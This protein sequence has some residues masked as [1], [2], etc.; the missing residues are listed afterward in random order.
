[1]LS[2]HSC[3]SRDFLSQ[4]E[5][6]LQQKILQALPNKRRKAIPFDSDLELSIVNPRKR[7]FGGP[8]LLD[9]L[10][11]RHW[12]S[13]NI[14]V[15]FLASTGARTQLSYRALDILTTRL[16][17]T[18]RASL[19]E[20]SI[21]AKSDVAI[22]ILIPQ[23]PE[24][25]VAWIA[26]LKVGAAFCPLGC[27]TPPE[28]L[29]FILKDVE[30]RVVITLRGYKEMIVGTDIDVQIIT[31]DELKDDELGSREEQPVTESTTPIR[32]I[33]RSQLAY[34]MYTSGSTGMPKGVGIPHQSVVQAL[35]AHDE[36]VPSFNR[37]LQFASPTFDVSIFETFFP[38]FRG[39]IVA[40]CD[41]ETMLGDLPGAMRRLSVDAAEL[42]PTVAASLLRTRDV[43][44]D[45]KFLMTIGE[46]LTRPIIEEF[47]QSKDKTGIL[48]AMY[49]PTEASIHCT[50][51]SNL[52]TTSKA[53]IIGRPLSTVTAYIIK[54]PRA[55]TKDKL[56]VLPVGHIGE[57]AV[58]GQLATS[59]INRVRESDA[60]F[61]D[62]A[63]HGR[64]YCTGDRARLLPSGELECLG[65]MN[66][67]QVKLRGQRVELGEIEQVICK[68]RG[69]N[70]AVATVIDDL[71][72]VFCVA[73][74]DLVSDADIM[75]MCKS[76]LPSFMRP[77]DIVLLDR[78]VP[79]LPS[80]KID[81]K[82]LE[83]SYRKDRQSNTTTNNAFETA[84]ERQ[85]ALCV[86]SVLHA[87]V[88]P[89]DSLSSLGMDS[90]RAITTAS[91][92]RSKNIHVKPCDLLSNITV[93]NVAKTAHDSSGEYQTPQKYLS[94]VHDGWSRLRSKVMEHLG[95]I[96]DVDEFEDVVPCSSVQS[97]MLAET[98]AKHELN[99]NHI[100]LELAANVS[101][102][103]LRSAFI[104]LADQNEILRSGFVPL[105]DEKF[106]FVQVVRRGLH[107][108]VRRSD[109][110]GAQ[111]LHPLTFSY[112]T[113]ALKN[114]VTV[115]LHHALY[116]GWSWD[117]I[118]RD[119]KALI[120]NKPLVKR[121]Q[122]R[123][124]V[125]YQRCSQLDSVP[126]ET[127][128]YW[129]QQLEDVKPVPLPLLHG[130]KPQNIGRLA[131]CRTLNT[132]TSILPKIC[133]RLGISRQSVLSSS[134]A[135]LLSCYT[136]SQEVVFGC[137]TSGRTMPIKNIEEI[138]GPC[139]SALPFRLDF[140]E[141]RTI[142]DLLS[143]VNRLHSDML[144]YGSV[145]LR[146]IKKTTG[147]SADHRLF[148]TLFVWQEGL[149]D[150]DASEQPLTV[151]DSADTLEYA[152]VLEVE[153]R[154]RKLLAKLTFD[155][156]RLPS[157]HAELFL[158]QIDQLISSFA[159]VSDLLLETA[160][161]DLD[162]TL[163]SIENADYQTFNDGFDLISSI[164]SLS[165]KEPDLPAIEFID[166]FNLQ[167]GELNSSVVTYH[168][169]N[170][171][172]N[173]VGHALHSHSV[174]PNHLIC[175]FMEKSIDLY[176]S[177]LGV[178]KSGAGYFA[179]EPS[180]PLSRVHE[181][182]RQ[183]RCRILI[184]HSTQRD[185]VNELEI[186][187]VV[188]IDEFNTFGKPDPCR[189]I[190]SIDGSNLAY[191]VFTSGSTGVPK[192]V[193]ITHRN[194]ISNIDSLSRIYPQVPKSKLLQACS[195]AFDVSVFEIFFT[196]HMG[197]CLCAAPNDV[198]F[199]DIEKFVAQTRIT[200]L[201]STPS[202]AAMIL[203]KKVPEVKMLV[204]AG[205][206]MNSRVF[207]SWAGMGLKQGY[208]PS[209]T[210]NICTIRENVAVDDLPSNIGRPLPNTSLFISSSKGFNL[211]PRGAAGQIWVGGDQVGN[212]YLNE[213]KLTS[214]SWLDHP[215][216]GRV[217]RSGDIGR[218]LA[219]GTLLI[220]GRDDCQVKIRGQ[221]VE[222]GEVDSA[223]V[224]STI[225]S[226]AATLV[227]DE[228]VGKD[229]QLV[230]FWT[231]A[232]DAAEKNI[233]KITDRLFK[234]L[235]EKLPAYMVPYL[236]LPLGAIPLTQQGKVDKRSLQYQLKTYDAAAIRKFSRGDHPCDGP[237]ELS[238]VEFQI[239]EV[240]S[241][242]TGVA[243]STMHRETSFFA[244]GLD[245]ISCIRF[246]QKLRNIGFGQIDVSRVLEHSSIERLLRFIA[247]RSSA[248]ASTPPAQLALE[249]IF[250]VHWQQKV[251]RKCAEIGYDIQKILPCTPLQEAML[252]S[253]DTENP[254]AYQNII[255]F[256]ITGDLRR[257]KNSWV[258]M[259]HKHQ[260]LRT[261]F[262]V[263]ESSHFPYAQVV[264]K[265]FELPWKTHG[266]SVEL[267]STVRG[268]ATNC[269]RPPYSLNVSNA[270][271][272]N[273][274]SLSLTMHH[275]LYD[276]EAMTLLLEDIEKSYL[277]SASSSTASFDKY[278][279][280][281]INLDPD[282]IDAF[283]HEQLKDFSPACVVAPEELSSGIQDRSQQIITTSPAL[284]LQSLEK[285]AQS[286]SLTL[287]SLIQSAW[288]RLLC[289]YLDA[290]D[291]CFG[292]VYSG[293]NIPVEG[294]EEVVGPCFNTLPVR[295]KLHGQMS[296]L[297]L[298]KRVQ[299][300]NLSTLPFQPSSL[301]R[302]QKR[303]GLSQQRLFNTL[304]LLQSPPKDLREEIWSITDEAGDMDFP[305]ICEIIPN[306]Q[307]DRL[308]I[309]LRWKCTVL[310][311]FQAECILRDFEVLLQ[312]TAKYSSSIALDF[313]MLHG[314]TRATKKQSLSP[315]PT[316]DVHEA[317]QDRKMWSTTEI[318]VRHMLA[319]YA[320]VEIDAVVKQ[321][322]IFRLGLDS[323]D[324]VQIAFR[325][326]QR[327]FRITGGDVLEN[328]TVVG[329]AKFC[330]EHQ[331]KS[332]TPTPGFDIQGFDVQN[333]ALVCDQLSVST[334]LIE[335]VWPCTPTQSGILAQ[336][337]NSGGELYYNSVDLR[338]NDKIDT[339]RLERAWTTVVR[340][341]EMLRTGFVELN[342]SAFPFAMIRYEFD[343][344]QLPWTE[345]SG[346]Q[347]DVPPQSIPKTGSQILGSLHQPP[348]QLEVNHHW[349]MISLRISM[350]HS[351]YDAESL[352]IILAD[353]A[354]AYKGNV[355]GGPES[356]GPTLSRILSETAL[357]EREAQSFYLKLGKDLQTTR[358]P[359]LKIHRC[360]NAKSVVLSRKCSKSSGE[361][362]NGCKDLEITLQVATQC[363]WARLLALYT[364]ES[365][366]TF[367]SILSGRAPFEDRRIAFPCM[368]AVPV[369]LKVEGSNL[370][371]LRSTAVVNSS[372][373]RVQFAPV[374][375]V[376]RWLNTE[377]ELFDTVLVLQ[378]NHSR[379]N[380]YGLWDI[381]SDNAKTEYALSMEVLPSEKGRTDLRV[382]T[383]EN[384]MPQEHVS[385]LL[386]QFEGLLLDTIFSPEHDSFDT[387]RYVQRRLLS[388][389]PAREERLKTSVNFLHQ[390]V[391]ATAAQFPSK[392]A[393]EFV[394][395]ISGGD[396]SKTSWSYEQ[397]DKGGNKVANLLLG[398][399]AATGD[400][401]GI[402]FDKCPEAYFAILGIL[403][404]GCAYVALDPGAPCAR[405]K[406]VLQDCACKILLCT[407][408]EL[409]DFGDATGVV[410]IA[411]DGSADLSA[412][413]TMPPILS[414]RFRPED[415][416]YC[417]YTSGTTGTPKGCLI[418][419]ENAVQA[420]L[421]FTRLFAG[422]WD[423][424]SRWLQFASFHFDVSVLEQ[425]WSWSVGICVISAP[426][427]V[428]FGDLPGAIRAL[429]I[430][431]IDL[432][433]SLARL[434]T[435][436][437]VP[438]LCRGVFITG[439]EQLNED[440]LDVWGDKAV[441][442]NGYGPSEV[443]I[444]CTMY[445]RMP[446]IAKPTNIGRQFDNVG[447]L[448]LD[449]RTRKPVLRGAVGEL[450]L[451]GPLVGRG[452]LNRPEL[453]RER[454]E[455][456]QDFDMRIYHTGDLVRMLYDGSFDFLGR[457]D[458]Q[459]KLRGQRLEIGEINHVI[460][461]S[462]GIIK[463]VATMVVKHPLQSGDQL[464]SF[465]S[466]NE[467]E[468]AA[469]RPTIDFETQHKQAIAVA[470][471]YCEEHLPGYMVPTHI[472]SVTS[473]PLSTNNKVEANVLKAIF[474]AASLQDLQRLS[475]DDSHNVQCVSGTIR[476]I[477]LLLSKMLNISAQ[478]VQPTSRLFELG[479]DSISAISFCRSMRNAGL[480]AAN[481]IH[482]MK[483][484]TVAHLAHTLD[485]AQDLVSQDDEIHHN[486]REMIA[487]FARKHQRRVTAAAGCLA[488]N[489]EAIAPCTPLQEGMIFKTLDSRR[490]LYLSTFNYELDAAI[491]VEQLREAWSHLQQN[492]QLL[493]TRFILTEDG[494]AQVVLRNTVASFFRRVALSG[495]ERIE[496]RLSQESCRWHEEAKTFD[497]MPWEVVVCG[498]LHRRVM[499]LHIFHGLY[500]GTSLPLLLEELATEYSGCRSDCVKPQFQDVLAM[501]PLL[502]NGEAKTY[503]KSKLPTSILLN[504]PEW[505]GGLRNDEVTVRKL[506]IAQSDSLDQ[507]RFNL[508]V[509]EPALF[510]AAWL[511]VLQKRFAVVPTIGIAVSGRSID[512]D[513]AE[514][515]VG[516]LFNT[517]PCHIS[518]ESAASWSELV[519][520]CHE[521][522]IDCLPYQH[523][524]LRDIA[525]WTGKGSTEPLFDTLYVF[526]KQKEAH[527]SSQL[528][529]ELEPKAEPD[530]P[531]AIEIE[532]G[533]GRSFIC[534]IVAKAQFLKEDDAQQL[535]IDLSE[536]LVEMAA[537]PEKPLMP[538]R[539]GSTVSPFRKDRQIK[540]FREQ[541]TPFHWSTAEMAVRREIATLADI[542]VEI[543]QRHSSIFEVGL[544]SIDAIKLSA[545]LKGV[546]FAIPVSKIMRLATV[547]SIA[548]E[549]QP[550]P[551]NPRSRA[552]SPYLASIKISLREKLRSQGVEVEKYD[553]I[554]PVTPLQEG[555]LA[556][557][558]QYY[559][560]D[561]LEL[562]PGV[563]ANRLKDS[564]DALVQSHPT[565]RTSFLELEDAKHPTTFVQLVNAYQKV[566]WQKLKIHDESELNK[567]ISSKR[568]EA[569]RDG[570]RHPST[571]TTFVALGSR[572]LLV[573]GMAH[574][575]YDGWSINLLHQDVA[576][577]YQGLSCER[578]LYEAAIEH[579]LGGENHVAT[580]FWKARLSGYHS[581][582]FPKQ[583]QDKAAFDAVHRQELASACSTHQVVDFCRAQGVTMQS[584]GLTCW[585]IVLAHY[586]RKLDVCFGLVLS[587]RTFENADEMMFPT[588][589]TVAFRT[590]LGGSK[591]Q[592]LK[593][594]HDQ[595]VLIAEHQHFPLRK[596]QALSGIGPLFDTLFIFQ[597]RPELYEDYPELYRSVGGFADVEYPVNVEMEIE[598]QNLI[599]RTA[600]K[601]SVLHEDGTRALLKQID[602]V[603][604][605]VIQTPEDP[606]FIKTEG[607][608]TICG[609]SPV[610]LTEEQDAD[611]S[612][613]KAG[614]ATVGNEEWSATEALIRGTLARVAEMPEHKITK[615][616]NLFSLGLDSI[617]A[618]KVSSLLRQRMTVLPVSKM[619]KARTVQE[620]ATASSPGSAVVSHL[621]GPDETGNFNLIHD[622]SVRK[623]LQ[624]V[625]LDMDGVEHIM[626][627]TAG[628]EYMLSM[629]QASHG[630]LFYPT[631]QYEVLGGISKERLGQ[632]W[633]ALVAR[634]PALR[635]TFVAAVNGAKT[636]IQVVLGSI[637][638]QVI[639]HLQDEAQRGLSNGI[640]K[641]DQALVQAPVRL[642]ARYGR[643][644]VNLSLHIHHAIYD[645]VSLPKMI[646]ALELLCNDPSVALPLDTNLDRYIAHVQSPS[647]TEKGKAFWKIYLSGPSA[648]LNLR[649]GGLDFRRAEVYRPR[650]LEVTEAFAQS[651]KDR[652]ISF[653]SLFL[654]AYAKLHA[655][656]LSKHHPTQ[657]DVGQVVIGIYLA[658]RSLDLVGLPDLAAPTV[659]IVPLLIN[660]SSKLSLFD[661]AKTVQ[662]D[663]VEIGRREHCGVSLRQVYE[664]TG[665]RIDSVVNFLKL[666]EHN[667]QEG[668]GHHPPADVIRIESV[669][670]W[671]SDELAVG[672]RNTRIDMAGPPPW[673]G[674]QPR[675]EDMKI[676]LV[677]TL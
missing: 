22:P 244:L 657:D 225:V 602:R 440:I 314:L 630:R 336:F 173:S 518:F 576:R 182:L 349:G 557:F 372:L 248:S 544:D 366:V 177:I 449:P 620:M 492:N 463:D 348:W 469:E 590:V 72:V 51:A 345:Y 605:A 393:I 466:L 75:S 97:A 194:L 108:H 88:Y 504:L 105:S 324:A 431:H 613:S 526:Q 91:K 73:K 562:L 589:N 359:D 316:N 139:I 39:A 513:G 409:D 606:T 118:M 56:E 593:K 425:F 475:S 210:T 322:T 341:H 398:Y 157:S 124:V 408:H 354:T 245:S 474:E 263:T 328:A 170:R 36:H 217:Y 368:N 183:T 536:T 67:G 482:V 477:S 305:V 289:C 483:A 351:M 89:T 180:T 234:E 374:S 231:P 61:V 184:S 453:T 358:F 473:I 412:S 202:L 380:Q 532:Q 143:Y 265:D 82:S 110:I 444:G 30:A 23:C 659:N 458:D 414:H 389:Q 321:T 363:A 645:G 93:A 550:L 198:L 397:L 572:S 54:K 665:V 410:A 279:L 104:K 208:G 276:A 669:D 66:A 599:W 261:G 156:T 332:A 239:A 404:A 99:F 236:L 537:R 205:E 622:S 436:E 430:T 629:W 486:A 232:Q 460:K 277:G 674:R 293:R 318:D 578:P 219:D 52:P 369:P 671:G 153:T 426:R 575:I 190:P 186:E 443:T 222:L 178:I 251:E 499:S 489:I 355:L 308:H 595:S 667:E 327:G 402:C 523:T 307:N 242:V 126:M 533:P 195:P 650:L 596:A 306:R 79:R 642:F 58:S 524:A 196:W 283:W 21:R 98:L 144:E 501:G 545:R 617:S 1:M 94:C 416:C 152:L 432:T 508:N 497:G 145:S 648:L 663:L 226:D 462:I 553:H 571:N 193:L 63:D 49:G 530:Y 164:E 611:L 175:V 407:G 403:K 406:F 111:L 44:P 95:S 320:G 313:S 122:Y 211:M 454:F 326:R 221:R 391:E 365:H 9:D 246:A 150:R 370:A 240:L 167:T 59:Y 204:T 235:Q 601:D 273:R 387:C 11:L 310:S 535:L 640:S 103:D 168:Q 227:A 385:I 100:E 415:V 275:A 564:W 187:E 632:A 592:M 479:L 519:R 626:P 292:N 491:D 297:D 247:A 361:L 427:D 114:R 522:N 597:K 96:V 585:A 262:L 299:A 131:S 130:S 583:R 92:L 238:H 135:M 382:T 223:L 644:G 350:L 5:R 188:F 673:T 215:R 467:H 448:V 282:T 25:Y 586:L 580:S 517:L 213:P 470:R 179:L 556:N 481:P 270:E 468:S 433:P 200:H 65:R 280:Y 119:L 598:G 638:N 664:W 201:S 573:L 64:I 442:Y 41:R 668:Q 266:Q 278:L 53:G 148:D 12:A 566:A 285:E 624:V 353:V 538:Q 241:Q 438:S 548:K 212:G 588:M 338:L 609:L 558:E 154:S 134:F 31:I 3:I 48:L 286:S 515:V 347:S 465:V 129:K 388:I 360:G 521:F 676:F 230:S 14:A 493:R 37:F 560:F 670:I 623:T 581:R 357:H 455:V 563:D 546:G 2:S 541:P 160:F 383:N 294:A 461:H 392:V 439:G 323:I 339:D 55:S 209:E 625:G 506:R 418:T 615:S 302:I 649:Q 608:T 228:V 35:L 116:D 495:N 191:A 395:E 422:H 50:V 386:D 106:P 567:Y 181:M 271:D 429:E 503:W 155:Q 552:C 8:V 86:S 561:V 528:W 335:A 68:L 20:H 42:T 132:D 373:Q 641:N 33:S 40:C 284:G 233:V 362:S 243:A 658:N 616:S 330:E 165:V 507:L 577:C 390:F 346:S 480:T 136:G 401:V 661:I 325:L 38:L 570:L 587:C 525:K 494:Y 159:K 342:N 112:H 272:G 34:I 254:D 600:C 259:L 643:R 529:T 83:Y 319:K 249:R 371:F 376:K 163:L 334:E 654:A 405:K 149:E 13:Q 185:R 109:A 253:T 117:L 85:I 43:V 102:T 496:H 296:N 457:A 192:G 451:S 634:L 113:S 174:R 565:L 32:E 199:R 367:G 500:D 375:K 502:I 459:V 206:P 610:D 603:L 224:K 69:I 612:L 675:D 498:D 197:M 384:F 490:P 158:C 411:L 579:N 647:P 423:V 394:S 162:A 639:W 17:R 312:H 250:P 471:R 274:P 16:A 47:G 512:L 614:N 591:S 531:L 472:L 627:V 633:Q 214:E 618:I 62:L 509:T 78:G 539:Q 660:V 569:C 662:N 237:E 24:M 18:L 478:E 311:A 315:Q 140:S 260:I 120:Y 15:D 441:I 269:A 252:S 534:T 672:G 378:R 621:S 559:S 549:V 666:P 189:P 417:L 70:L 604:Q 128:N 146:D 547:H 77:A 344:V 28:R 176:V 7:T 4:L 331:S 300:I 329:I 421:S 343:A 166:N 655:G 420:M 268:P 424:K 377:G 631:F 60:A 487:H 636:N 381:M 542:Q 207:E 450:C 400:L 303:Q 301:R 29:T 340:R 637:Q 505:S 399:G 446:K 147:L 295:V 653:Q 291:I 485:G 551:A 646:S 203:P 527:A 45:L 101:S 488:E 133:Q 514:S 115:H 419:H 71:L 435:P 540:S 125:H 333:R 304:L 452:Y 151:V 298:S 107:D 267:A 456:R 161:S 76:W 287:S 220:L 46:M 574:A 396:L 281:M 428:L 510:H 445:P 413:S 568:A 218:L 484:A 80:G 216:Y 171:R 172:G 57:L 290:D 87:P 258:A 142:E 352:E 584:L 635:T 27:D 255:V 19:P 543:V 520:L 364:N 127:Q 81:Q 677:R 656:L 594:V 121:P 6:Q 607:E 582:S 257:L 652:D 309:K 337:I 516:P 554:L 437:E 651:T 84:V 628:Q 229:M 555:M 256:R 90:L 141:L 264:L 447:S 10:L 26:V 138:I 317:Q 169:L 464:V 74:R 476:T 511:L 137:V 123:D 379:T 356:I 434:V 288:A 619:L